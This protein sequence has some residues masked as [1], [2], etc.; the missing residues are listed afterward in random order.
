MKYIVHDGHEFVYFVVQKVACSSIKT[1]LRPLFDVENPARYETIRKD[2][3]RSFRVHKLF[4]ESGYQI[5]GSKF[6]G[7][8]EGEY[9]DYFK[10]AFVRNPWDRLVS[11]YFQKIVNPKGIDLN[12]PGEDR[13]YRSMQFG[14]FV[15]VV[16]AIPDEKANAHFRSQYRGICDKNRNVL[17]NFV[18]RFENLA[19]DFDF[20]A[21]KIG[22]ER[23][24]LPHLLRSGRRRSRPYVEFYDDRLR[25]LVRR[26]FRDDVEIF[27]YSF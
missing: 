11:C 24:E 25:E 9:R 4:D 13:F 1:A 23:L 10:F 21:K 12:P 26:R 3:K 17:A 19:E 8:V 6:F 18:G 2:G 7:R 15:E 5:D 14:E 16:A 22:D 20:V 27:G